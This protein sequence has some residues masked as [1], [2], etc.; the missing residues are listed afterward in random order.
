M[1]NENVAPLSTI[2]DYLRTSANQ[3]TELQMDA[4]TSLQE[5]GNVYS[6]IGYIVESISAKCKKHGK[7]A[8]IASM[9]A[10]VG[11]SFATSLYLL[12]QIWPSFSSYPFPEMPDEA[13]VVVEVP[14]EGN[15]EEPIV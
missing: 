14:V 3:K 1:P 9:P 12:S 2:I 15:N 5:M 10:E 6:S 13:V 4:E 8:L 11:V 7:L